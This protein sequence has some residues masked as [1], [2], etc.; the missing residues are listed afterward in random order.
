M[1]CQD[2]RP[3]FSQIEPVVDQ[4]VL[5]LPDLPVRGRS[6]DAWNLDDIEQLRQSCRQGSDGRTQNFVPWPIADRAEP[7]LVIHALAR[8]TAARDLPGVRQAYDP[9][10]KVR[11]LIAHF[12]LPFL[13][14]WVSS[15]SPPR[16]LVEIFEPAR[17]ASDLSVLH[18]SRT[19]SD[20]VVHGQVR[21]VAFLELLP[22]VLEHLLPGLVAEQRPQRRGVI[23]TRRRRGLGL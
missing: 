2:A 7:R 16:L 19:R 20:P 22:G 10:D 18:F 9:F 15:V 8:D 4:H 11:R 1:S 5:A 13:R 3:F 23:C 6:L 12:I 14:P 17:M 21:L